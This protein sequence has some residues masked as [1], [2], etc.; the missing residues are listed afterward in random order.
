MNHR[1]GGRS[2]FAFFAHRLSGIALAAFL[3]LHFVVLGLA[4]DDTARLDGFLAFTQ[5]PVVKAAETVL[6]VLLT[7]HLA[8]GVRLLALELMPW[9]SPRDLRATWVDAG[10]V[11]AAGAGGVFTWIAMS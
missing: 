3:P 1:P 7:V 9:K 8:F 5:I 4:L 2:V 10:I 6:V 11:L